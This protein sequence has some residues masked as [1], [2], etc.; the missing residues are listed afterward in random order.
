MLD[1]N[2]NFASYP[3]C[4]FFSLSVNE[5]HH[6]RLSINFTVRKVKLGLLTI[7]TIKQNYKGAI[8]KFIASDSAISFLISVKR[9]PSFWKQFLHDALAMDKQL[10]IPIG[11]FD[12]KSSRPFNPPSQKWLKFGVKL[13]FIWKSSS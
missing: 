7:E 3:D 13:Y 11:S 9:T 5:H 1:F 10:G 2:Q 8:D 4:T 12:V 6:L